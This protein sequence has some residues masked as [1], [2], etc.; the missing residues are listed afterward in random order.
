MPDYVIRGLGR[1]VYVTADPDDV[2]SMADCLCAMHAEPY[3]V[4]EIRQQRTTFYRSEPQ[5]GNES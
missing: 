3:T 2:M 1:T 5:R 4:Y